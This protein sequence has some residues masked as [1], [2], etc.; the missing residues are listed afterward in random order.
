MPNEEEQKEKTTKE[1]PEDKISQTRHT[2]VID[3]Q[4]IHY[5]A[6]T[7]TII[8]KQEEEGEDKKS[9]RRITFRR[10]VSVDNALQYLRQ[11]VVIFR[12][13]VVLPN[14]LPGGF[15]HGQP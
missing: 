2:I 3:G 14:V 15:T 5:T 1:T 9:D 7:G 12:Q 6:T 8:L 10:M 4:E 13:V 11:N